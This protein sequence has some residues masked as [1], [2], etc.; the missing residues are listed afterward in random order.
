MGPMSVRAQGKKKIS[1]ESEA[2]SL[3]LS[4]WKLKMRPQ[5]MKTQ[6]QHTNDGQLINCTGEHSKYPT[7]QNKWNA[8]NEQKFQ[9]QQVLEC[10]NLVFKSHYLVEI[11][12]AT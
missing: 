8:K 4:D 7:E 2:L 6:N 3:G 12:K 5:V 1:V 10:Q 11:R 9:Q